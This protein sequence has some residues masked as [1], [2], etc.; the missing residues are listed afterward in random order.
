MFLSQLH[1]N[2]QSFFQVSKYQAW[3]RHHIGHGAS[4]CSDTQTK[5]P[6]PCETAQPTENSG[7]G[8]RGGKEKE[9]VVSQSSLEKQTCI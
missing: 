7:D 5:V 3:L 4:G 1:L 6:A 2:S 9:Q 8:R